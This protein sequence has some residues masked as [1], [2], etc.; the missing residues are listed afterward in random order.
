[1]GW[2]ILYF[3]PNR[4]ANMLACHFTLPYLYVYKWYCI[5]YCKHIMESLCMYM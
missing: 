1:M 5:E 3:V 4:H 2:V